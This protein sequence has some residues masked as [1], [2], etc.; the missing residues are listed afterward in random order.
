MRLAVTRAEGVLGG[1]V[2]AHA[3]AEGHAVVAVVDRRAS[4]EHRRRL[5]AAGSDVTLVEDGG[6]AEGWLEGCDVLVDARSRAAELGPEAAFARAN[7][8]ASERLLAAASHG[9]VRRVVLLSSLAVHGFDGGVDVDVRTR[10]RDRRELPY[11][12]ALRRVED[13]VLSDDRIEGVVVRPGLWPI[14]RADPVLWRLARALRGGRLPLVGGGVGV[15]NLVDAD[16]L[17]AGVV[18]AA[19]HPAAPGRVYAVA[20]PTRLTW[21]DALTTLAS[22]LGG[23]PPRRLLP[24]APIQAVASVLER[25]YGIAAPASEPTLTRYRT[26][27]LGTGL[28]VRIDH[29]VDELG[30]RPRVPWRETLRRAAVDALP[31]LGVAPRGRT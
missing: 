20:E 29:A 16:D 11:A 12:H 27:L 5:R 9:G 25:A 18:L 22:L 17:A 30:W 13:L 14:G 2:V 28:H 31:H 26:A 1:H 10:P 7:A 4:E 6:A 3:A 24:T 21:R 23:R 15:L 8:G 19:L